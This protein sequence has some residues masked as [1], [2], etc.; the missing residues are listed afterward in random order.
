MHVGNL[1]MGERYIEPQ[2]KT[3]IKNEITGE[4]CEIDFKTR[5]KWFNSQD[6]VGK[7][8]A[9]VKDSSG[10]LIIRISGN[11]TGKVEMFDARTNESTVEFQAPKIPEMASK[12]FN[13]N[14]YALQ[15]NVMSS[16]L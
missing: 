3:V 13:F 9:D 10:K 5:G 11:Y 16:K 1:I 15:L 4:V 7:I 8:M 2:G 14:K 12:M 6:G